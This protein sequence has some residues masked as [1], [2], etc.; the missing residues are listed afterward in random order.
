LAKAVCGT[1][2]LPFPM[3][4]NSEVVIVTARGK[5]ATCS[6]Q[7]RESQRA[8]GSSSLALEPDIPKTYAAS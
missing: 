6:G 1:T 8:S 4:V 3:R 5:L 7:L 2:I